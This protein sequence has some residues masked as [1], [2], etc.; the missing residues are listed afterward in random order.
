MRTE[1]VDKGK[2][3]SVDLVLKK[4]GL[5]SKKDLDES[6]GWLN[7]LL[8]RLLFSQLHDDP[9]IISRAVDLLEETVADLAAPFVKDFVVK[10]VELMPESMPRIG[11][12]RLKKF[13]GVPK[14]LE[15]SPST[16]CLEGRLKWEDV[17]QF[18]VEAAGALSWP[19]SHPLVLLPCSLGVKILAVDAL[20]RISF[21]DD[22]ATELEISLVPEQ[23]SLDL[24]VDSSI[25]YKSKLKNVEKVTQLLALVVRKSLEDNLVW[26]NRIPILIPN[27]SDLLVSQ[28]PSVDSTA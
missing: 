26:P 5:D 1:E 19:G 10:K 14:T 28:Q 3:S 21:P 24:E 13:F 16:Y 23:F 27:L 8:A 18:E 15:G 7:L 2:V 6:C 25:G 22:K 20:V 17:G 11:G 12:F 9:E 4:L